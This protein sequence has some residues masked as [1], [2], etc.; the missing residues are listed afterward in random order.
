MQACFLEKRRYKGLL[1]SGRKH[2]CSTA[3]I[4]KFTMSAMTG[5]KMDML[6][7]TRPVGM[8]SS[9]HDLLADLTTK[10][11]ISFVVTC[12]NVDSCDVVIASLEH[13]VGCV[14]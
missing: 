4:D 9:L 8:G 1:K 2:S 5:A 12:W 7:F 6:S 13:S 10:S 11:V 3:V 14:A